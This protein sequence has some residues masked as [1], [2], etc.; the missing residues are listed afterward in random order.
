MNLFAHVTNTSN[1]GC[2]PLWLIKTKKSE[3]KI[4]EFFVL[5]YLCKL[6]ID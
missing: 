2:I 4:S 1:V 5:I 3:L 6:E